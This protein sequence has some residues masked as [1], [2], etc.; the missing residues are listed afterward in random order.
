MIWRCIAAGLV[1]VSVP[2]G[3]ASNVLDRVVATVNSRA[4]LRSDV[5]DELRYEAFIAGS[6]T[7]ISSEQTKAALDRLI[8]QELLREQMRNA[9]IKPASSQEIEKQIDVFRAEHTKSGDPNSWHT[10]LEQYGITED[11]LRAHVTLELEQLHFIEVRLRPAV[12]IEPVE[13]EKYYK[14]KLLPQLIQSGAKQVNP[15]DAAPKIR[16]ILTQQKMNQMLASW[17]QT[18]HSQAVI[19]ILTDN[20]TGQAG[21][22]E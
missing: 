10:A 13:V 12:Q 14:E 7:Q 6:S 1:L 18:L 17:L 22:Q 5:E 3:R 16:E 4:I 21:S 11:G 19:K 2:I 9:D 8:D 20:G 15:T